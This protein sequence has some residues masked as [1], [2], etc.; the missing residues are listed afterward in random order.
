[1]VFHHYAC[2]MVHCYRK[3]HHVEGNRFCVFLE[4]DFDSD[5]DDPLLYSGGNEALQNQVGLEGLDYEGTIYIVNQR[6]QADFPKQFY[7]SGHLHLSCG[8]N[9][10][11]YLCGQSGNEGY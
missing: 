1:M 7:G 6:V 9:D 11:A 2:T 5:R 10:P 3:K 4:G 8:A